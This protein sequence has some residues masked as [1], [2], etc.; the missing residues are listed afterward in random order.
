MKV[1]LLVI[2]LIVR[3]I[4]KKNEKKIALCLFLKMLKSRVHDD[5]PLIHSKPEHKVK[6]D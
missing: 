4:K 6:T 5:V 3:P 2:I 1:L